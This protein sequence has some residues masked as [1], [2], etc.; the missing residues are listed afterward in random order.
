MDTNYQSQDEESNI[1]FFNKESSQNFIE[2]Y[3]K[4][5]DN[6]EKI[7]ENPI[8]N[9]QYDTTFTID[10][11]KLKNFEESLYGYTNIL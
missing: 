7:E 10:I 9:I 3:N 1:I 5:L 6:I 11:E 2:W 8:R 4:I